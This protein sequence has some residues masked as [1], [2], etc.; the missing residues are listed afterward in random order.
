MKD[1]DDDK[2]VDGS[3]AGAIPA[4]STNSRGEYQGIFDFAKVLNQY[5]NEQQEDGYNDRLSEQLKTRGDEYY[6]TQREWDRV[7][8]YGKV[9]DERNTELRGV[10]QDRRTDETLSEE[11]DTK[12]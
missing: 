5:W 7:V 8:G 4:T 9:P 2:L 12:I 11:S 1:T 3:D 6:Y 10:K